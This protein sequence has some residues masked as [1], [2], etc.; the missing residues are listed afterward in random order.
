MSNDPTTEI[1][2]HDLGERCNVFR[3]AVEGRNVTETFAAALGE[4]LAAGNIDFL[5]GFEAIRGESRA[6]DIQLLESF[7]A[8]LLEEVGGIGTGPLLAPKTRLERGE[9]VF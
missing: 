8:P 9:D 5:Q 3:A 2:D 7:A 4:D 1:L 6:D